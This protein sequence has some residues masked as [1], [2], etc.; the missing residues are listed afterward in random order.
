M[1]TSPDY[2]SA[3]NMA[4]EVLGQRK[5]F[6]LPVYVRGILDQYPDIRV[7][8]YGEACTKY[9]IDRVVL[10]ER[11]EFGFTMIQGGK[12]IILYNE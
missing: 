8:S 7:L 3:T 2:F 1:T 6:T 4:Y 9:K 11:S 5:N 10:S 12:R